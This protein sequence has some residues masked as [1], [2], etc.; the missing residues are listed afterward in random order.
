MRGEFSNEQ[1]D[2]MDLPTVDTI[3]FQKVH[4]GYLNVSL[5]SNAIFW[6]LVIVG[7]SLWLILNNLTYP[8]WINI[9]GGVLLLILIGL[10]IF[11]SYRLYSTMGYALRQKDIV[12]KKGYLW[13]SMTVV[14]FNRIQHAEVEQG[15]IDRFFD[16]SRLKIYTAGGSSSDLDIPGLKPAESESIKFF[17][18]DRTGGDEEE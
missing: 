5:L 6:A 13:R 14:P 18:L 12:F 17:I 10:S 16:L 2:I 11:F 15:P 7:A 4:K 1:L 3:E 9:A 8:Q